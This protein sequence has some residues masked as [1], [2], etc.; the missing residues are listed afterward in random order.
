MK[1]LIAAVLSVLFVGVLWSLRA[2]ESEVPVFDYFDGTEGLVGLPELQTSDHEYPNSL[3]EDYIDAI[4]K[5]NHIDANGPWVITCPACE[6]GARFERNI[7][8]WE[9]G[10]YRF[11]AHDPIQTACVF[12]ANC[13]Y[14]LGT[15]WD[16][17]DLIAIKIEGGD[18]CV[19]EGNTFMVVDPNID[20]VAFYNVE[21][22]R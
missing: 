10:V 22:T 16:I 4:C 20:N 9:W 18:D 13:G 6:G 8:S 7:G 3:D 1:L 19:I 2:E 5:A 12:C 14:P 15:D 21:N 17:R 11:W